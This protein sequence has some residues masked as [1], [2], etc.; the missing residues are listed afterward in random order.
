[1]ITLVF[2]LH[3]SCRI[4]KIG[5]PTLSTIYWLLTQGIV[6]HRWT[7]SASPE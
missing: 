4:E 2:L 3:I 7:L 6:H 5:C 1:M